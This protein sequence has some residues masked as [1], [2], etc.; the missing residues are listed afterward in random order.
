M[1]SQEC[2]VYTLQLIILRRVRFVN[3]ATY[4]FACSNTT[5]Y[6]RDEEI[7]KKKQTNCSAEKRKKNALIHVK[8]V[9]NTGVYTARYPSK[10]MNN[11]QTI[12]HKTI[13]YSVHFNVHPVLRLCLAHMPTH[14]HIHT[15]CFAFN[16]CL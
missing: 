3:D 12:Y 2:T 5:Y 11:N 9:N 10:T 6:K 16:L 13:V 4:M 8:K 7:Q 14:T 1:L 15:Y